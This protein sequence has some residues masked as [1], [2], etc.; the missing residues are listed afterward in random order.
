MRAIERGADVGGCFSIA[1]MAR[2]AA[3]HRRMTG[4]RHEQRLVSIRPVTG[5][6]LPSMGPSEPGVRPDGALRR[7]LYSRRR[8]P[9]DP[10]VAGTMTSPTDRTCDR[11][12][13][14]GA[15]VDLLPVMGTEAKA[16]NGLSTLSTCTPC[17]RWTSGT[18][19]APLDTVVDCLQPSVQSGVLADWLVLS[20]RLRPSPQRRGVLAWTAFEELP[21]QERRPPSTQVGQRVGLIGVRFR[22]DGAAPAEPWSTTGPPHDPGAT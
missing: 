3:G 16:R 13:V 8:P 9:R 14:C 17:S 4:S 18:R 12:N 11:W 1:S 2:S 5:L 22:Q 21:A 19:C 7:P 20:H 10:S 6:D 15:I